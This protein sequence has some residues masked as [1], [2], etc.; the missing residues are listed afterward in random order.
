MSTA[1]AAPA[2]PSTEGRPYEPDL[3]GDPMDVR[4]DDII[5]NSQYDITT[6]T[7]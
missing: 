7:L 3:L 4:L 6:I 2:G 1:S 5:R